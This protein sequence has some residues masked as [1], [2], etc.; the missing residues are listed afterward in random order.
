MFYVREEV[1]DWDVENVGGRKKGG[2][3]DASIHPPRIQ[4]QGDVQWK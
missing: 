3:I 4:G 1:P 2:K